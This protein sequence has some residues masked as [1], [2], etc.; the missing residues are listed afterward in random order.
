MEKNS[1]RHTNTW[2]PMRRESMH[3]R[4]F[5][6]FLF[7]PL[8]GRVRGV[9]LFGV[10]NCSHQ[11]LTLFLIQVLKLFPQHVPNSTTCVPYAL[12]N[13]VLLEHMNLGQFND[14]FLCMF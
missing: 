2:Q 4:G 12:P 14:L 9:G 8:L 1:G 5:V 6:L 3:P 11:V 13:V 7:F 10:P